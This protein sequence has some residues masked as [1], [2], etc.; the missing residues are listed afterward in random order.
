MAGYSSKIV[1]NEEK[2]GLNDFGKFWSAMTQSK[3]LCLQ[4]CLQILAW[5]TQKHVNLLGD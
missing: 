4:P 5:R 1:V 3:C 2:V